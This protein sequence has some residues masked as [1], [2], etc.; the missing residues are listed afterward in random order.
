MITSFMPPYFLQFACWG[1]PCAEFQNF[2]LLL[3]LSVSNLK[4]SNGNVVVKVISYG[5][6]SMKVA[7]TSLGV[8]RQNSQLNE[9]R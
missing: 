8:K 5:N 3:V 6:E 7:I 9:L 4:I 1:E 2:F